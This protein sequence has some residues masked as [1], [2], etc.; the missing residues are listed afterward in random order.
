[1][2][3]ERGQAIVLVAFAIIALAAVIGLAL[4]G[5]R[6]YQMRRQVQNA[7]DAMALAGA[8]VLASQGCTAGSALE[9]NVCQQIVAFGQENGV[10]HNNITGRIQAWYVNRDGTRIGDACVGLGV[11]TGTT[12]VEVTAQITETTTFMRVVGQDNIAPAGN[13]MAMF[14]PVVQAGGGFLPIGFPVQRVDSI[15]GSG[16]MQFTMFE[17]SGSVCRRDGVDC[18]S[19]PPDNAQRGWLN[20]DYIY[21]A[22]HVGRG[23]PLE[24]TV[25]KNF[26]N[27][28]L[29]RWAVEG[30]PHPLFAGTRGGLPP[31]YADGDYIAGDPGTRDVTRRDI[32][33]THMNRTVYLPVFDYVYVRADMQRTF[34]GNQEPG[35]GWVNSYYYHIVGFLAATLDSCSGGGSNGAIHGTFQYATIGQGQIEP[36]EGIGSGTACTPYLLGVTLWK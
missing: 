14:G 32:C 31:Y 16:N 30:C 8:R 28:D 5:G 33:E 3:N 19:N 9:T 21:N 15:I 18:P 27:A 34:P 24:R 10:T 29:K 35:I 11:P 1:M 22:A 13:A 25:N 6:M 12:G 20:F 23:L 4:D 26:S 7:A 17:G 2:K 36:G